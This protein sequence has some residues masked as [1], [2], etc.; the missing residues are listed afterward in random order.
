MDET[1]NSY[2]SSATQWFVNVI[3]LEANIRDVSSTSAKWLLGIVGGAIGGA[4]EGSRV[5][6]DSKV[7]RHDYFEEEPSNGPE[8]IRGMQI[9]DY[10]DLSAPL[11]IAMNK[12]T[13]RSS[14]E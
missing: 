6:E 14:A 7:I 9:A 4:I 13:P 5:L 1:G 11:D 12:V 3:Y 8:L 10:K 2:V